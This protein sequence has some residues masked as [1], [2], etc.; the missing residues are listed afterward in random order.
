[1]YE[2][3]SS[4]LLK[5]GTRIKVHFPGELPWATVLNI[6]SPTI[7]QARLENNLVGSRNVVGD[8]LTFQFRDTPHA[9]GSPMWEVSPDNE[10]LSYRISIVNND[11]CPQ[12]GSY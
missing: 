5:I 6:I 11:D 12:P 8:V 10:Q 2:T 3:P 4:K 1:M 7:V 9:P